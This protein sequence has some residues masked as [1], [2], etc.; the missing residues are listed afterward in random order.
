M[1]TCI[2][3]GCEVAVLYAYSCHST[4]S[5]FVGLATLKLYV[6]V[7]KEFAPSGYVSL[8]VM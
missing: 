1:I 6:G 8:A 2:E 3:H 5:V 7:V 4:I